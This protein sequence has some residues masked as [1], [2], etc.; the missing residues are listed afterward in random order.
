MEDP[1]TAWGAPLLGVC[2]EKGPPHLAEDVSLPGRRRAQQPLQAGSTQM[3]R[4]AKRKRTGLRGPKA[5]APTAAGI[6]CRCCGCVRCDGGSAIAKIPSQ[7]AKVGSR[8][9]WGLRGNAGDMRALLLDL[10]WLVRL[11]CQA[12]EGAPAA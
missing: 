9:P 11:L 1:H 10:H 5:G 12:R 3:E 8:C 4:A 6:L 2:K 7:I